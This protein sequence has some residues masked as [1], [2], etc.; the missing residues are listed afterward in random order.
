MTTSLIRADLSE[1]VEGA[2]VVTLNSRYLLR[3][4]ANRPCFD[5]FLYAVSLGGAPL[6]SDN[7][8]VTSFPIAKTT[9]SADKPQRWRI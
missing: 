6:D 3:R 4:R 2:V 1:L 9:G 5:A 8:P 7:Q